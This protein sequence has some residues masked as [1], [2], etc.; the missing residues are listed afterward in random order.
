MHHQLIHFPIAF[1][2]AAIT[3]QVIAQNS[4]KERAR[5]VAETMLYAGAA[6]AVLATLSGMVTS[7]GMPRYDDIIFIPHAV[8]GF[9]TAL[10]SVGGA[11]S[12]KK[13]RPKRASLLLF[14]AAIFVSVAGYYGGLL[15]HPPS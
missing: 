9:A 1:I 11:L 14:A 6:A 2:L 7:L 12:L 5:W 4:Q 3:A 13:K 8:L 15:S 10:T